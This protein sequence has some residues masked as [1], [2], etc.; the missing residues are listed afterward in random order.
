MNERTTRAR[1]L[2]EQ[3]TAAMDALGT[4]TRGPDVVV[5]LD[6]LARV[7]AYPASELAEVHGLTELV[8]DA[9]AARAEHAGELGRV[10]G[11]AFDF[12][13]L[14]DAGRRLPTNDVGS[15]RDSWLRDVLVLTTV[16]P[17][18]SQAR[19]RQ[20]KWTLE[21]AIAMVEAHAEAF[22]DASVLESDRRALE[23]PDGLSDEA[24]EFLRVL[25]DL[26]LVVAFDRAPERPSAGRVEAALRRV[27]P[28]R[29]DAADD[30]LADHDGRGKI[31]LLGRS[32]QLALAAADTT[33]AVLIRMEAG[34]WVLLKRGG[35]LHLVF[36]GD[37]IDVA[38]LVEGG[39]DVGALSPLSGR[40]FLLPRAPDGL[41]LRL[42]VGPDSRLVRI[43]RSGD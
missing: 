31:R 4:T 3:L 18:L 27:D 24:Q 38:V 28:A 12:D 8:A 14:L 13:G 33:S 23:A 16:A 9:K 40:T 15:E 25:A 6:R 2:G 1:Y 17:W 30:A 41:D 22:L 37:E 19:R 39:A 20:A 26:P 36:E 7:E 32:E 42:R 35:D 5:F 43:A 11:L 21:K 29:I 34:A 10:A